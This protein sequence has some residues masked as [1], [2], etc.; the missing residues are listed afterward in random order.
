MEISTMGKGLVS[1]RI[2]NLNDL[3]LV[4][5]GALIPDR[6]R[7]V[8]VE[9]ALVD[10]GAMHLSLPRRQVEKLGLERYRT[11]RAKTS[12]G[13]TEIPMCGMVLLTV[14]GRDC[15]MEVAELPDECPVLIGQI[16]L[17]SLDFI[18]DP[19]HQRLLGNPATGANT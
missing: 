4:K 3:F 8:E 11:R 10:T 6:V 9:D 13:T 2:E 7:C 16:P 18:V 1:A 14:Q 17:E 15:R 12:A 19:I 5:Q